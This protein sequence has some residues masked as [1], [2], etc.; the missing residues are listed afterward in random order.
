MLVLVLV[1][2]LRRSWMYLCWIVVGTAVAAV[3]A[4]VRKVH[5]VDVPVV[6]AE[7]GVG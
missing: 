4:A 7:A 6:A 2:L 1:L 3:A 5:H